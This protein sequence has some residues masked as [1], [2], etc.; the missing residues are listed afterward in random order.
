LTNRT[1]E[2]NYQYLPSRV[3]IDKTVTKSNIDKTKVSRI[4]YLGKN[5]Q[6]QQ[7][8]DYNE[9]ESII[10]MSS[11]TPDNPLVLEISQE[12][13]Y[14]SSGKLK[15]IIDTVNA[16]GYKYASL[17]YDENGN[18][19]SRELWNVSKMIVQKTLSTYSCVK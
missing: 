10:R 7:T 1:T 13:T 6:Y 15:Q 5:I 2:I 17:L 8:I 3:D 18:Q 4:D 16:G 11:S 14:H 19:I 12:Y 9:K